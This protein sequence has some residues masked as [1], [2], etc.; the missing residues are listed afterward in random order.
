VAWDETK[1]NMTVVGADLQLDAG[2][3]VGSYDTGSQD[4]GS[5][6]WWYIEVECKVEESPAATGHSSWKIEINTS[7]DN[8]L[9]DGWQLYHEAEYYCRY[10]KL[11]VT[12]EG[13]PPTAQRPKLTRLEDCARAAALPTR[14]APVIEERNAPTGSET[15]GDRYV[16][17]TG[18]GDFAGYDEW[19]VECE[20]GSTPSWRFAKPVEG[21][22]IWFQD[23]NTTYLYDENSNWVV[24]DSR[25]TSPFRQ[26]MMGQAYETQGGVWTYTIDNNQDSN[27]YETTTG[28][29]AQNDY[30]DFNIGLQIGTYDLRLM[31]CTGGNCAI[32]TAYLDPIGSAG[33]TSIGTM[34]CYVAGALNNN[35]A[36][37]IAAFSVTTAGSKV[38]RLKAATQNP[39][40]GGWDMYITWVEIWPN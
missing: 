2:E 10:Y 36:K 38:L 5:V 33:T 12:V 37:N 29:S 18:G 17:G 14:P 22:K 39:L 7:T 40:S 23:V 16:V 1:T 27:G 20:D 11:R 30:I 26:T 13:D 24:E 34:D 6:Q 4:K 3:I 15:R 31:T 9:W 8:V 25:K 28:G 19:I 21:T 35:V 32:I